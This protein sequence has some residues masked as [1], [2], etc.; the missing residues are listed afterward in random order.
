MKLRLPAP[1][2]GRLSS[3]SGRASVMTKIGTLRDHSMT[4]STK[5]TRPVSAWWKSSK[6]MTT[7]PDSARRSKNV[8][9][10]P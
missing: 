1:H 8:R 5:S 2:A 6:T 9:H 10:A 7:G 3:R 4:W